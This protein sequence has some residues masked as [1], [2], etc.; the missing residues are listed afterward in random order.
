[1]RP[2][3]SIRPVGILVGMRNIGSNELKIHLARILEETRAGE[4]FTVTKNGRPVA[5]LLPVRGR[6]S[7]SVEATIGRIKAERKNKRLG[8]PVKRLIEE[9][10]R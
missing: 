5:L 3:T 7:A 9:G 1:M 8:V 4:Q 6:R 2:L 10:R